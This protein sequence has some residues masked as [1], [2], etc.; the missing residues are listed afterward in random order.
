MRKGHFTYKAYGGLSLDSL[1]ISLSI[2]YTPYRR[3]A[4]SRFPTLI[5]DK[6]L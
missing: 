2:L 3:S 5:S 1:L 4:S 6:Q